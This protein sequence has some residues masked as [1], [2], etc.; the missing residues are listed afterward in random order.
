MSVSELNRET[1]RRRKLIEPSANLHRKQNRSELKQRI[2]ELDEF[3]QSISANGKK[4][5]WTWDM[6]TA[7][8]GIVQM[9]KPAK[10]AVKPELAYD[11]LDF[12]S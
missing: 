11:D 3:V 9:S 12:Y 6:E 2:T 1:L 10:K 5:P 8:K 4:Q 7:V